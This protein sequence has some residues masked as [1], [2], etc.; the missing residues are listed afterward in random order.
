VIA[1]GE[2]AGIGRRARHGEQVPLAGAEREMLDV[3]AEIDREPLAVRPRIIRAVDDRRV[4]IAA[5]I[6][7]LHVETPAMGVWRSHQAADAGV[8]TVAAA[9]GRRYPA[10]IFDAALHRLPPVNHI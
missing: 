7:K 8:R 5:V 9:A 2:G 6:G 10:T 4:R 1:P 3:E